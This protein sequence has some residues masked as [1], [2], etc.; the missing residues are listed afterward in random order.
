MKTNE[1][2]YKI[3]SIVLISLA[4]V[5]I[6]VA[7]IVAAEAYDFLSGEALVALRLL[8]IAFDLWAYIPFFIVALVGFCVFY[9]QEKSKLIFGIYNIF[10]ALSLLV[11]IFGSFFA[12][13]IYGTFGFDDGYSN[14]FCGFSYLM[15]FIGSIMVCVYGFNK[16]IARATQ[17]VWACTSGISVLLSI[18]KI[19]IGGGA[20]SDMVSSE[21][22]WYRGFYPDTFEYILPELLLLL[23]EIMFFVAVFVFLT[24]QAKASRDG[25]AVVVNDP[26]GEPGYGPG[27]FGFGGVPED[28]YPVDG[29]GNGGMYGGMPVAQG[30]LRGVK[31][32]CEGYVFDI[33]SNEEI[34]IGKDARQSMVIIDPIFKEVSRKHVGVAFDVQRDMYRVTDYS[35]NGTW[36]NGRKLVTGQASYL[37]RGTE[38]KL[39]NGKNSF[40]LE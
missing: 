39:A 6:P 16:K 1:K 2:G 4:I 10:F 37:S 34:I 22:W 29:Y 23:A 27:G 5:L 33:N 7:A 35:S 15:I 13:Y 11:V 30:H 8:C 3:T 17:I 25:N 36:A 38:L 26:V 19:C 21:P 9:K 40:R 31:G 18:I 14:I 24:Y 32:S 20:Y 28:T 12:A